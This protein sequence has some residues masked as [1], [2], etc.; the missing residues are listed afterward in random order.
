M[1][2]TRDIV[3][4][5]SGCYEIDL[6]PCVEYADR[7]QASRKGKRCRESRYDITWKK[8]VARAD[9]TVSIENF[10]AREKVRATMRARR[11]RTCIFTSKESCCRRRGK[12]RGKRK[13]ERKKRETSG[14]SS[15]FLRDWS[16]A[17]PGGWSFVVLES[18]LESK[19]VRVLRRESISGPSLVE[20]KELVPTGQD[21]CPTYI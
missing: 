2:E 15:M 12:K 8:H 10:E 20:R 3:K 6:F 4:K 7:K 5:T 16:N 13:K 17:D 9:R 21:L 19:H 18:C 1:I 11:R 14:G